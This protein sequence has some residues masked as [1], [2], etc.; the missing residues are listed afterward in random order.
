MIGTGFCSHAAAASKSFQKQP[1]KLGFY[2]Y[3]DLYPFAWMWM[4][5]H[6]SWLVVISLHCW[7]RR[8]LPSLHTAASWRLRFC[9]EQAVLCPTASSLLAGRSTACLCEKAAIKQTQQE[10]FRSQEFHS[11]PNEK[12]CWAMAAACGERGC[13]RGVGVCSV[14]QVSVGA[15]LLAD[16]PPMFQ[17]Q[18]SQNSSQRN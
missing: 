1:G 10:K 7:H 2:F 12:G 3:S 11:L 4:Y 6:V 15:N 14:E 17:R 13:G 16:S 5:T 8:S 9:E 18:S